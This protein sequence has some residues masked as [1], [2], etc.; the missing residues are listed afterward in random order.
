MNALILITA[1]ALAAV[2]AFHPGLRRSSAWRATVTPLSSIMGSGFLVCAPLL[3]A[4]VGTMAPLAMAVLLALAFGIGAILRFNIRWAEPLVEGGSD[5]QSRFHEHAD[6][7]RST[8]D[9][10]ELGTAVQLERISHLVLTGAYLISV[11]YYLQLFGAFVLTATGTSSEDGAR[12]I[13]T[14]VLVGIG[15]VGMRWGL[16]AL[17]QVER[18]AVALN[19]GTIAALLLGLAVYDFGLVQTGTPVWPDLEPSGDT[20]TTVR[21]LMGLLIVVQGFE[22]SRFLGQS[23]P[24]EERVRTMRWAQLL[25]SGI[26]LA[27]TSLVL[28][29]FRDGIPD[30]DVTAILA[31]VAPVAAVLP[32]LLAVAAGA[33]QM[34]AAVADEAGCA[35]LVSTELAGR[36]P[37]KASYGLILA[38]TLALTWGTDVYQIISLASRAFALFYAAQCAVGVATALRR[39]DATHRHAVI[40]GGSLLCVLCLAV[41]AFG[42]PAE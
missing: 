12:W 26:Y 41:A 27:F 40:A 30:A 7:T 38:A 36:L 21:K 29:L 37:S 42:L 8:W 32:V 18:Y 31:L 5:S 4:L 15:I 17:E 33:S 9:A 25:A 6:R 20:V 2:L 10:V 13:A 19:L 28:A 24:A 14:A 16:A 34:S 35:G 22:T 23:H 1:L 11:T 3:V 39:S